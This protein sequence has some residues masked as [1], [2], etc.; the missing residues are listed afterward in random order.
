MHFARTPQRRTLTV[1]LTG[2]TATEFPH[3]SPVRGCLQK[4]EETYAVLRAG[5]T[6]NQEVK[7][8]PSA[9]L[10]LSAVSAEVLASLSEALAAAEAAAHT[11]A[12]LLLGNAITATGD[13]AGGGLLLDLVPV[14]V[15]VDGL[16][17]VQG[18]VA[19]GVD[20]GEVD[21]DILTTVLGSDESEALLGVE[22][23]DGTLERHLWSAFVVNN[24]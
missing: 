24:G 20:G 16:A 14:G 5:G 23:L 22:E 9:V 3:R 12:S 17:L 13:V 1:A 4:Q 15:V 19:L 21:E 18:L 8:L 7:K 10:L 11:L 2:S 6:K